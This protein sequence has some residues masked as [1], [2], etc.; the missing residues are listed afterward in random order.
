MKFYEMLKTE[1]KNNAEFPDTLLH[2]LPRGYQELNHIAILNLKPELQ[3]YAKII[4]ESMQKILPS[5][6]AIWQRTGRIEGKYRQPEGLTHLWGDK[7]SEIII[8]ENHVKYKF[9]FT[10]IM[11]A[12]GNITERRILPTRINEGELIV[13]MFAGIGY[14]SLGIAKTKKPKKIYSI[15]WNPEA[16]KYLN[17]NIQINHVDSIITPLF[18]DCKEKVA[19]LKQKNILADRIIMG[20]LPA[21]VDAIPSALSIVKETGTII[22]YEGIEE[23]ESMKLFTEFSTIAS[24]E[25]FQTSLIERRIVK[26]YKPHLYHVVIEILVSKK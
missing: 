17:E 6:K 14:F 5:L 13:D 10:K 26:N 9:D 7:S 8:S 20:L 11:F 22:V 12:K 18:G 2:L 25:G 23:K 3:N 1:L 19:E 21:P 24:R 16:F 15:E 4:S